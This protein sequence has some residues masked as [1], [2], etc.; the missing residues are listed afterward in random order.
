[1]K[2][3]NKYC[4][5]GGQALIE[6]V[7]MKNGRAIAMSVRTPQGDIETSITETGRAFEG[8]FF[9]LPL[10]RGVVELIK[11]MIIG[12]KA[13][14]YSAE[15]Y[16]EEDEEPSKFEQWVKAKFGDKADGILIGFSILTAFG[17]A[18]LM[19]GVLPAFLAGLL[20]NYLTSP[21]WLSLIEGVIKV[22]LFVGYIVVISQLRDIKR[23]FEYH[24]A[25][26]KT[27]HCYE[28]GKP[29]T[30]ENATTFTRIHPRCGTS[31]LLFVLTISII[32]FSFVT[33]SSIAS[34]VIMKIVL[35]PLIAG[36]SYEV[37]KLSAKYDNPIL[38]AFSQPGLWMQRLTTR[39]P[40]L[41]QLA[42]AIAAMEAAIEAGGEPT[43]PL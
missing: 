7:M 38:N 36:I 14:T 41:R 39:E 30:P 27:I 43:C 10:I 26:H 6:G 37:L 16:M 19:F 40:N 25:E 34:R 23:V 28:A 15:F 29:L 5:I 8:A 3:N 9:K 35:M 21:I 18:F 24:G 2:S 42:V 4:N 11:A 13:L 22:A 20:R 12:V 33:W 17:M 32:V 31:F 1:M